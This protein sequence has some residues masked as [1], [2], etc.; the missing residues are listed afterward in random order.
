MTTK[1][2]ASDAMIKVLEDWQVD[3]IFGLP[4]GSFDST[5]DALYNRQN[6][7]KY[8][9]VRQ[10]ETGALAASGEAKLTGKI[11]VTFGSA[12]PG[13]V[14]LLNGLYDAKHDHAP[15][16]ALVG[17][18]GTD[19]M[20]TEY[21]QELNE[22]PIFADV[23]VYNRTVMTAEQLPA[24]VDQ[25][26]LQ[27]YE[28]SGVAVVTIPKDL[29]WAKI[30]DNYISKAGNYVATNNYQLPDQ[31]AVQQAVNILKDAKKPLIYFGL[32]AKDANP[33]LKRLS[34]QLKIPLMSSALAKG[35]IA[36][37]DPA[38]M[39][40]AGRVASKPGV[41]AA[42]AAD[43]ILF[44]GS[45]FPFAPYFFS[46]DAKFIQVDVKPTNIGKRHHVDVGIL[47]DAK[48]ILKAMVDQAP[49]VTQRPFY[50]AMLA[51]KE[52]WL[53]WLTKFVDEDKQPLNVD[54]V[55]AQI[56]KIA[57]DDA[58]F[59]L[60]VGNVTIDGVRLLQMKPTQK[61]TTS[62]WY[63]TMGYALPTAIGAQASYPDRQVF[64]ISG[65]GGYTM[66]MHDILTQVKY[67]QPIINVVLT[68]QSLGFIEAE[69]DDTQ[70]PHSGVDLIDANFGDAA[71]AL[72]AKGYEVHT[73]DELKQAFTEAKD[74]KGPVVIDVKIANDR[75]LPVEQLV[76][77]ADEQHSQADVDAFVKQ[78]RA[79]GLIPVSQ[80]LQKYNV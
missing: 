64:S 24:V 42:R 6:T 68:N 47:A 26:I 65:D 52:N 38:Y 55:F 46:P 58:I 11:G 80:L 51:N 54:S 5:M 17:Q 33:E 72:G 9:Q 18:V 57:T 31:S 2:N 32:G 27:A 78:Y 74:T 73:L 53:K 10:E 48:T 77:E 37:S 44:I 61:I 45:N 62:G 75:P 16:L 30:D 34:D 1:I 7:M 4:G 43:A 59:A 71:T 39:S 22:N 79:D 40:S 36:D 12:G 28:H 13:A 20:N 66:V 15:V 56:N 76:L 25:A 8:I 41:E 21:F 63:A 3:H 67:Q 14:H 35:V 60:D 49:T 50:D 69:Q 23:A 19:F 70:Q 29:G